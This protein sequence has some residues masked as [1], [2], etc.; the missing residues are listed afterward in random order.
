MKISSDTYMM[1]QA[2]LLSTVAPG[3]DGFVN[4]TYVKAHI[5]GLLKENGCEV[6]DVVQEKTKS[7]IPDDLFISN[8]KESWVFKK[9][10]K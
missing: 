5:D 6:V 8:G 4:P 1:M 3:V 10:K 7:Q 2:H 9:S